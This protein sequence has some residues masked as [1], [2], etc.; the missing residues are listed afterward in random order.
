M[1]KLEGRTVVILGAEVW[2][3]LGLKARPPGTCT[4]ALGARYYFLPHPS[5]RN[6]FYNDEENRRMAGTLLRRLA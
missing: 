1:K 6:L 3:V 5:G 2:R 4:I